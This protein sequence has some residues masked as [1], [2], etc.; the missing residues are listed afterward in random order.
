MTEKTPFTP[1][2]RTQADLEAAW[3]H[4][5]E[6]L[7]FDGHSLWVMFIQADHTPLPHL[8]QV[9]ETVDPPDAE[10]QA[11]LVEFLGFFRGEMRGGE[12]VAFLRSRPGRGGPG[13]DDLA[14]ARSLYAACRSAGVET[15]VVHLATDDQLVP[16]PMDDVLAQ[17]A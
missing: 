1:T 8:T 4:L 5:M 6:P 7:G 9:E 11:S 2:I 16:L 17:P 12:R 13:P 10:Q 15:D 14:W 3:R